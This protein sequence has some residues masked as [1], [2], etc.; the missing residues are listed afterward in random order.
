MSF[1]DFSSK[2][3]YGQ[4][5]SESKLLLTSDK[6]IMVILSVTDA[7]K[8]DEILNFVLFFD[9]TSHCTTEFR[10]CLPIYNSRLEGIE[11]PRLRRV[12]T[13]ED[14]SSDEEDEELTE[15]QKSI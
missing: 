14:D 8:F 1:L 15:E 6:G 7:N 13:E 5:H 12:S 11:G 4:I 3:S 9:F 10:T 2:A